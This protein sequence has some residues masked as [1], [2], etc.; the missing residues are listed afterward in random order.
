MLKV[1]LIIATV[2]MLT[3]CATV[4]SGNT[5]KVRI[6]SSPS[7]AD[8]YIDG[9]P[10]GKTPV[11]VNLD[12]GDS[13]HVAVQMDGYE[14]AYATIA[15]KVGAGWVILDILGG[16]IPVVIDILTDSW[17]SLSPSRINLIL[18]PLAK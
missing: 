15:S 3:S 4:F 11:A 6:S 5:D 16:L 9:L 2:L 1:M 13:Y 18:N 12:K 14:T 17:Y 7:G 10:V 8:V